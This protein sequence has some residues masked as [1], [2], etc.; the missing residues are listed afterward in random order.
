MG[1]N[2]TP[3]EI[4]SRHLLCVLLHSL[5]IIIFTHYHLS[6][7]SSLIA[8]LII[9]VMPSSTSPYAVGR[10][11]AMA[12]VRWVDRDTAQISA[13]SVTTN[14]LRR[15]LESNYSGRYS[16]KLQRDIFSITIS[17]TPQRH[18]QQYQ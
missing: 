2:G 3:R 4:K 8:S 14:Q 7:Q 18:T 5:F 13:S 9:P 11:P 12:A 10:H 15:Y 1:Q 6:S 16:V 17:G